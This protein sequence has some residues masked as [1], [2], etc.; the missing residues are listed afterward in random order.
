MRNLYNV[1]LDAKPYMIKKSFL[2]EALKSIPFIG[3]FVYTNHK[4][5]EKSYN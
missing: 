5:S 4:L 1:R 3:M 2:L